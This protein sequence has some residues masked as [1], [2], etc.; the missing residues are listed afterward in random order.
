MH[1][2]VLDMRDME[3][4]QASHMHCEG[5]RVALLAVESPAI[6][7]RGLSALAGRAARCRPI[8]TPAHAFERFAGWAVRW[9]RRALPRLRGDVARLTGNR[10]KSGPTPTS[11]GLLRV[12]NP[13]N[14]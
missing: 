6:L 9:C 1:D 2:W 4:G 13:Q 8:G 14:P 3:I 5:R 11:A 12:Y 10:P 7:R